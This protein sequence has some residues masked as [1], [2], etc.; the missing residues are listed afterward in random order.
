[1]SKPTP[2]SMGQSTIE[3]H[4]CFQNIQ[5]LTVGRWKLSYK[6]PRCLQLIEG[7]EPCEAFAGIRWQVEY[8]DGELKCHVGL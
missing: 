6:C 1:M 5:E 3:L 4:T 7:A 8:R 2:T